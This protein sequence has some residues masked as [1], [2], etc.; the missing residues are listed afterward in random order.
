MYVHIYIYVC[1]HD[2]LIF[3]SIFE[4]DALNKA[5]P[6]KYAHGPHFFV[7]LWFGAVEF[8]PNLQGYFIGT[9]AITWL[10]LYK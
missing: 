3:L 9:E 5:H 10:L 8:T 2:Y 6:K 7:L 1:K 4:I